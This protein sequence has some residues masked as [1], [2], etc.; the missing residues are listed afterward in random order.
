MTYQ[1]LY[2]RLI[3]TYYVLLIAFEILSVNLFELSD[4][5]SHYYPLF[6]TYYQYTF[7][8]IM[9]GGF[10]SINKKKQKPNILDECVACCI[11]Y[12]QIQLF[13]TYPTRNCFGCIII[14]PHYI[15]KVLRRK[16]RRIA[17]FLVVT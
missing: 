5:N 6:I 12:I 2:Y 17:L 4:G 14:K 8:D 13:L 11:I 15:A 3:G 1:L 7:P 9:L 16:A 10:I